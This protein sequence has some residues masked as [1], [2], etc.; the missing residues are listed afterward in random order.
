LETVTGHNGGE[1]ALKVVVGS[2]PTHFVIGDG[3]RDKKDRR[4][5][6][7]TMRALVTLYPGNVA[8]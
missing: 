3:R 5:R 6:R 1:P 2:A 4:R 7:S 8:C